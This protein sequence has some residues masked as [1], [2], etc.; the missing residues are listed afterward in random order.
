MK[1]LPSAE[2]QNHFG[3][4]LDLAKRDPITVTQYGRPV[5]TMMR[6]EDAQVALR[7][8]AGQ[9]MSR[10]LQALPVNPEAEALSDEQINRLVHEL[11]P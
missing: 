2:V 7:L 5:V 6:Y 10:F 11:R 4:V 8:L 3:E 9:K 1:T